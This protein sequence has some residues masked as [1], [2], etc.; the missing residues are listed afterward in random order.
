MSLQAHA[1]CSSEYG[2]ACKKFQEIPI[3]EIKTQRRQGNKTLAEQVP[4]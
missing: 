2:G 1:A 4:I 3:R